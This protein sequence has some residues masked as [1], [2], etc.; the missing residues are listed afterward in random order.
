MSFIYPSF[1]FMMIF[2]FVLFYFIMTQK[3]KGFE[4]FSDEVLEKLSVNSNRLTL[5]ARNALYLL[6]FFFMIIALS[7]PVIKGEK[8]KVESKSAD[9][10]VALD[11][12]NSM[13]AEDVYPSRLKMAKEKI[14]TLL[15]LAPRERIG[16]MAFG[17]SA[18]LIA[19]LSFDHRA[20]RFLLKQ[21]RPS[22]ISEKGTNFQ[23]LLFSSNEMLEKNENKYL[24]I[25]SD[26]GD[27]D[28]LSNEIAYAK[29]NNIKVFVLG[30]GTPKGAPIKE[31]NGG[32]IKHNGKIIISKLNESVSTLATKSGGSYIQATTSNKDIEAMLSEIN[33]KTQK[34]SLKEEEIVQNTQLFQYPL[35]LSIFIL[36]FALSSLPRRST[37]NIA[38]LLA[39]V[40][41]FNS[42]DL[43]ADILDFQTLE[44]AQE[45]YNQKEFKKS[46][47]LYDKFDSE[48]AKYNRANALYNQ[49]LY[50]E[51]SQAYAGIAKGSSELYLRSQHNLG[52]TYAKSNKLDEAVKAYENS[53]SIKED[54]QTR[55]NLEAVKKAIKKQKKQKKK[56]KKD[57][58]KDD[59][60]KDSDDK[61]DQQNKDGDQK[62]KDDKSKD[63]D[64]KKD[65][66]D[67]KSD[68]SKESKEQDKKD[69]QK[70]ENMKDEKKKK[71]DAKEKNERAQSKKSD[72]EKK[73]DD[74]KEM[75]QQAQSEDND[76]KQMSDLEQTKWLQRL[77]EAPVSHIYKLEKMQN[78]QE[79]SNEKPW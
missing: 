20:V 32:F 59:E 58:K 47:E 79:Q 72:K 10:M 78:Q 13:L 4:F 77:N 28:N 54:E 39:L 51:A 36:L 69:S 66:K 25:L 11:I 61:K 45:A 27:K 71:D 52:N 56:D 15:S 57:Q 6:A 67:K 74:M 70:S 24:L 62:K 50:K 23:Q 2:L 44:S 60:K 37:K 1:F 40:I 48:Q 26:G 68:E 75:Q 41:V 63:G 34:K 7:Q 16:V 73:E 43:N 12:S 33:S 9:I 53:L 42:Y 46:S 18:Y 76:P 55:E 65:S 30:M 5:N 31:K 64:P 8:I 22:S 35:A 19:P 21:L 17:S 38:S 3:S 29:E 49:K 14:L